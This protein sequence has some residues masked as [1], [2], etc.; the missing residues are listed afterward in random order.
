MGGIEQ[1]LISDFSD[2]T[3]YTEAA[4]IITAMTQAAKNFYIYE[5]EKENGYTVIPPFDDPWIIAG[6]GTVG[7]E[8]LQEVPDL[9]SMVLPVPPADAD[10]LTDAVRSY[11]GDPA[12]GRKHGNAGRERVLR[13]FRPDRIWEAVYQEYMRLLHPQQN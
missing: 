3:A 10:A 7:L 12:L 11:M 6:Q 4:G 9:K 8:V 13:E 1:V 5:L 2:I